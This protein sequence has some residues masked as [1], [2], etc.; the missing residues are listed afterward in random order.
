MGQIATGFSRRRY[1]MA[2]GAKILADDTV[3]IITGG[4]TSSGYA[5]PGEVNANLRCKGV[6]T[7]DFRDAFGDKLKLSSPTSTPGDNTNGIDGAIYVEVQ[8]SFGKNGEIAFIR[9]NGTG[10]DACT[11][12]DCGSKVYI[13]DN[14]TASRVSTGKSV[15]GEL[16]SINP[17]GTLNIVM[18]LGGY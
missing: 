1:P 5:V 15:L 17:D 8:L 12:G 16:D 11:Q 9:N 2:A 13:L 18:P 14:V 10:A 7:G 3:A 6:A 4:G